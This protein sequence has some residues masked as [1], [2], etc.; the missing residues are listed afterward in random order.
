M[1]T[2]TTNYNL[3]KPIPGEFYD[4]EIQNDNMDIIDAEL[5]RIE[6]DSGGVDQV[7]QE[8][9]DLKVEFI[10]HDSN[11]SNPHAVTKAQ[12]GLPTVDN[13]KQMPITGGTFTGIAKA[14]P[15]T[16]YT[17]AQMRNVIMSTGNPTGGSDSDIW[18]KYV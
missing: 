15:N 16:S 4:V 8:L 11:K 1:P 3:V 7:Q 2:N 18:I 14:L 10:A 5:K 17:V 12:V 13:A 6:E 9:D